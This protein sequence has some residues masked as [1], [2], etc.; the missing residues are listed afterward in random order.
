MP[1]D[2][3][4]ESVQKF[5]FVARRQRQPSSVGMVDGPGASAAGDR[6]VMPPGI[7]TGATGLSR[8]WRLTR[9]AA[10]YNCIWLDFK[11]RKYVVGDSPDSAISESD[12][13]RHHFSS[14]AARAWDKINGWQKKAE[15]AAGWFESLTSPKMAEDP[16]DVKSN[17]DTASTV[18]H[19]SD[20]LFID[21]SLKNLAL[22]AG[23]SFSTR[24]PSL[25]QKSPSSSASL[26]SQSGTPVLSCKSLSS[27]AA[28]SPDISHI[29]SNTS[30]SRRSIS[31]FPTADEGRIFTLSEASP[32]N[33]DST[34]SPRYNSITKTRDSHR[35]F[36]KVSKALRQGWRW[37][38]CRFLMREHG[39]ECVDR[40]LIY[41]GFEIPRG[42]NYTLQTSQVDTDS[43]KT[44]KVNNILCPDKNECPTTT[45]FKVPFH[46]DGSNSSDCSIS[47][48]SSDRD[49][50]HFDLCGADI[51]RS[52][53]CSDILSNARSHKS[54]L[55]D[56]VSSA[57]SMAVAAGMWPPLSWFGM[58]VALAL[59]SMPNEPSCQSPFSPSPC[60]A[61]G[62]TDLTSI[63][64]PH[65]RG[66]SWDKFADILGP[67]IKK[68]GTTETNT[69]AQT[70]GFGWLSGIH[71]QAQNS[72]RSSLSDGKTSTISPPRAYSTYV[73]S[74]VEGHSYEGE[75]REGKM[76]G[77]GRLK[78]PEGHWYQGQFNKERT[79]GIG[80]RGWPSG[81]WYVGEEQGGWKE[82]LGAMGWPGGRR[83]EGEFSKDLRNGFGT[84]TWPDGRWYLGYWRDG[85][86]HGE[87][88]EG[89]EGCV[90]W[91]Q[92][93]RGARQK[94]IKFENPTD[95]DREV[96]ELLSQDFNAN[97]PVCSATNA[98]EGIVVSATA[99]GGSQVQHGKSV[100]RRGR[101]RGSTDADNG[102]RV[103]EC[104]VSSVCN[105]TEA[106]IQVCGA[107]LGMFSNTLYW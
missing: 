91:V 96:S 58:P 21:G 56:I 8:R 93:C 101:R 97:I 29:L 23:S 12:D 48:R 5:K 20:R 65:A 17:S 18:N 99:P 54:E 98:V 16:H 6:P 13:K 64:S 79:C 95:L 66:F 89:G 7:S 62:P 85:L 1:G 19:L 35:D 88:L 82:G 73:V 50:I 80:M 55:S 28:S 94:V 34:T 74:S 51:I 49:A 72:C 90:S 41:C 57:H 25:S 3:D 31:P 69:I 30:T 52:Q 92:S 14:I 61:Q 75:F 37:L 42:T 84:M 4:F 104:D 78:W 100:S 40:L 32:M 39:S 10:K 38:V 71:D 86:Q 102:M 44:F 76:H 36:A 107:A 45:D 103:S 11:M 33:Y 70:P 2:S 77:Y 59:K 27:S 43:N 81:H 87:G 67:M 26:S 53:S 22:S 60:A 46:V 83:Y 63:K 68:S 106:E 15:N 47:I 105:R 24:S 9:R